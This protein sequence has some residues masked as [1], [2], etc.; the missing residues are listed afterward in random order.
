MKLFLYNDYEREQIANLMESL[1]RSSVHYSGVG[2]L[3]RYIELFAAVYLRRLE[4]DPQSIQKQIDAVEIT[5]GILNEKRDR[6]GN[7]PHRLRL[8]E[9]LAER[10]F[11]LSLIKNRRE[12]K[13]RQQFIYHAMVGFLDLVDDGVLI[14][15][16][17]LSDSQTP[18]ASFFEYVVFPVLRHAGEP[19]QRRQAINEFQRLKDELRKAEI[20]EL[21]VHLGYAMNGS[22]N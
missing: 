16:F 8:E 15:V 7:E 22:K 6:K 1:P 11:E 10:R 2:N 5:L 3:A 18:L 4:T 13:A 14:E 12:R 17:K 21:Q 9:M 20:Q 19:L